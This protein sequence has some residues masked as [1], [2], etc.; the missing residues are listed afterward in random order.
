MSEDIELFSLSETVDWVLIVE[1][2]A[3]ISR[4]GLGLLLNG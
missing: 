3:R 1:K 2:D 4:F